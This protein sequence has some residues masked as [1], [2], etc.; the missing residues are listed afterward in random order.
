NRDTPHSTREVYNWSPRRIGDNDAN[1]QLDRGPP[2]DDNTTSRH[3]MP[4]SLALC[5]NATDERRAPGVATA[6]LRLSSGHLEPPGRGDTATSQHPTPAPSAL[7]NNAAV[8]K[9]APGD[10]T[11]VSRQPSGQL[12]PP[13]RGVGP[14]SQYPTPASPAL[15]NNAAVE[16]RAPGDASAVTRQPSGQLEPPRRGAGPTIHH[17]TPASPALYNNAADENRAPGDASAATRQPSGQL[18]PPRRGAGT[19]IHHPTPSSPALYNNAAVEKRAPG[20]ATAVT[21]QPGGQLEPPGRGVGPTIHHPAPS[22][23]ALY[24][25]AAVEKRAPGDATAVSR[26]PSDHHEPPGRRYNPAGRLVKTRAEGGGAG[27]ANHWT[28]HTAIDARPTSREANS[29]TTRINEGNDYERDRPNGD[30]AHTKPDRDWTPPLRPTSITSTDAHN[31][32]P[33]RPRSQPRHPAPTPLNLAPRHIQHRSVTRRQRRALREYDRKLAQQRARREEGDRIAECV[34]RA[35]ELMALIRVTGDATAQHSAHPADPPYFSL[36]NYIGK[37]EADGGAGNDAVPSDDLTTAPTTVITTPRAEPTTSEPRGPA[38]TP[39]ATGRPRAATQKAEPTNPLST[40]PTPHANRAAVHGNDGTLL[41]PAIRI[42]R[43]GE[44]GK[45]GR[46]HREDT[47]PERPAGQVT[48]DGLKMPTP[49]GAEHHEPEAHA[50]RHTP[51]QRTAG[52]TYSVLICDPEGKRVM[53]A[54]T[55]NDTLTQDSVSLLR[56]S[57]LGGVYADLLEEDRLRTINMGDHGLEHA[58][59]AANHLGDIHRGI[60]LRE[61][62]LGV[63]VETDAYATA[64]SELAKEGLLP[65]ETGHFLVKGVPSGC[66]ADT[67]KTKLQAL[68]WIVTPLFQSA[69]RGRF[70]DWTVQSEWLPGTWNCSTKAGVELVISKRDPTPQPTHWAPGPRLSNE[71]RAADATGAEKRK[72]PI[73]KDLLT[74][75][76]FKKRFPNGSEADLMWQVAGR[77]PDGI[78]VP[79][80]MEIDDG[81]PLFG[82]KRLDEDPEPEPCPPAQPSTTSS[83]GPEGTAMPRDTQPNTMDT[84]L[85]NLE[86]AV[87]GLVTMATATQQSAAAGEVSQL[88]EEMLTYHR[89]TPVDK[90]GRLPRHALLL[91]NSNGLSSRHIRVTAPNNELR[92]RRRRHNEN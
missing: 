32:N 37:R 41:P 14:T 59:R 75:G 35:T 58:L 89:L 42:D 12:G 61:G 51:Q 68:G 79:G 47:P 87:Q 77:L 49:A 2:H 24:N 67:L 84:R 63:R 21:R 45:R 81:R 13:G 65:P 53:H 26:L 19:T 30:D 48:P 91:T 66:N 69:A 64:R 71:Y 6:V 88:R 90:Q 82:G 55:G 4:A 18:E 70:T 8:E 40:T 10:V 43:E 25:N 74:H 73:S 17:P 16:K 54:V 85:G 34:R 27:N 44:I 39:P 80:T 5:N 28:G 23:P 36:E 31:T 29:S 92:N 57:G 1:E 20:D 9:R 72:D 15:Y 62:K 11:A 22:S 50:Q 60:E 83:K 46:Q 33:R 38:A 56:T 78:E 3:P 86:A 7:C 76:G 52:V